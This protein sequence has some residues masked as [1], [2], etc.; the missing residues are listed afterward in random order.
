[1]LP[2]SHELALNRMLLEV[3]AGKYRTRWNYYVG[4]HPKIWASPKLKDTFRDL[5][6]SFVENYCSLAINARVSRLEVTGFDGDQGEQ[7]YDIWQ[8]AGFEQRQDVMFR[9]ALAHG[10][11][12]LIVQDDTV[13]INPATVAYAFTDP[14]DWMKHAWAG[15]AWLDAPAA[16]WHAVLW[17][18]THLYR[19]K[20]KAKDQS[21]NLPG[22]QTAPMPLGKDF[23]YDSEEAHGYGQVPVFA[24]TPFG[25]GAAPLIDQIAPIQ[26]KINKLSANKF[27]AAEFGAFK[28]RVF[29]TRQKL[30]PSQVR[31]QP[32]HAIVL[33]PGDSDGKASVQE[34]GGTDL[35]VYDAAKSAEIDA[36]FT[37]GLLPRHLRSNVSAHLSGEAMKA[38]EAP[39]IESLH[40]HQREFGEALSSAF[41]LIGVDAK[42]I[43]RDVETRDDLRNAQVVETL[44]SAGVPWQATVTEYIGMDKEEVAEAQAQVG[45]SNVAQQSEAFLSNPFLVD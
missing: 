21:G 16:T 27:V 33:D 7:A 45:G 26:D 4:D 19:Y 1:M 18:E 20:A 3:S 9:W 6:D 40:D 42:P 5:A 25:W 32:D 14:D 23:V 11:A 15:K 8:Q 29:F 22:A 10:L 37:I 35:S 31:Q 38:D 17:D 2:D 12:Y 13:V 39:F 41:R 34:L 28:Q 36:L 43:W 30:E 44:A 24:V